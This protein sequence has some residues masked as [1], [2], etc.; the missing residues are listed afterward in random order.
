MA[1]S[2][3]DREVME[4]EVVRKAREALEALLDRAKKQLQSQ[5]TT[6]MDAH[7]WKRRRR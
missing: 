5:S 2:H 4:K 1:F 3:T 7:T 6:R